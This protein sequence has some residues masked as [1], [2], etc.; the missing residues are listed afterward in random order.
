MRLGWY[1]GVS[2]A[3]AGA[4]VISAFQQ[5]ANFYSAMV[6]LAQSNFC[7]LALVNFSLL[8]YSSFI[9]G[10][11]K[12]CFGTLRAVEVEQLTERAWFAIT[13]TCLAM[14][15]FREEIGAWFLV[16]FT[17]LVTGKVWGWIGDGRVEFLEQQPPANPRLFHVRL[18]VSL[19]ISFIYDIWILKYTVDT[20]I[21]QARPNM[22]VMF[23]FEFAV[24]ATC[25][26]RTAVR[27]I[28]SIA[29][30]NIVK[31]Q[32]KK[33]L[34][35]RR[36]EIRR[37][38]EALIR[39]REQAAATGQEPPQDQEP[40]PREED[41]DE[42]DIEVP[43]WTSKGEW[44]LWLD[45]VTDMIK[46]GIYIAFFFMLLRFYGLPI[47]IM[48][49]LFITSR[50][51]I[52]RLNALL[53]YR[54][55]IQEMNRYPDATL[56]ELSQENTCII[57]REE[58]RPWDPVNHPGAIDRVRPKKL[59]CGH[60]LHLGC[61]KSWL[62]R[63]Q[64]CPTCRSPVT[65]DRVR[66]GHN[67]AAGLQIQIGG[68][69]QVLAG[70]PPP[71]DGG[72]NAPAGQ[73]GHNGDQAPPGRDGGPR[74][75]NLGPFR[76]GFGANDQQARELA[77]QFGIPQAQGNRADHGLPT[78][79]PTQTQQQ[80]GDSMQ[81]IG[82]LLGQTEQIVQRELQN[83]QAAQQE[84][85][86]AHLLMAELQRLRQRRQQQPQDQPLRGRG[87]PSVTIPMA[88]SQN[89]HGAAQGNHAQVPLGNAVPTIPPRIGS[90]FMARHVVPANGVTIPAGSPDLPEGITLPPGWSLI[91]LQ[92]L[93]GTQPTH[94]QSQTTATS[95]NAETPNPSQ[96]T[97]RPAAT[98]STAEAAGDENSSS[99]DPNM[100]SSRL[101]TS[102][103][104]VRD[105]TS[106]GSQTVRP[107]PVVS[108][109]PLIPNWGGP[110]QL[111][112]N[113]S[114]SDVVDNAVRT[115]SPPVDAEPPR[116]QGRD[117]PPK[118][119]AQRD[120]ASDELHHHGAVGSSTEAVVDP[121]E[122][123][124]GKAKAAT[125]EEAEEGEED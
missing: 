119:L 21:Q 2:T 76:L 106:A 99:M 68:G 80:S 26:W 96:S 42:M 61:L 34:I 17:S 57:C 112:N 30:Q 59:P 69:P 53:R 110:A 121:V 73:Q 22:M 11:T 36:Q 77:Q 83:L 107:T 85:Q 3:L 71:A 123:D 74:V 51:F 14:T 1:A 66:G 124:K 67:R 41:I 25:S 118:H 95:L 20:V 82:N 48:R 6:Y 88:Q 7:L 31:A 10:L 29:E 37:Q 70:Q 54:R 33:R 45:L 38:R 90:P 50:D 81:Q 27:Y 91:P 116:D 47:H 8:L 65:M 19:A 56:E 98:S 122:V 46:L 32:T 87:N 117:E 24:L 86:V 92:R 12:L 64:V 40:L 94:H 93:D 15:I 52:K 63:Q 58:M 28:L 113:R 114:R 103:D 78:P 23:L 109:S 60:V 111:F 72:N 62:E 115:A 89:F 35:E 100:A 4:V 104:S 43:G 125:V 39:E 108:P 49:D 5:R 18:S 79:T 101:T 16:M 105:G 9:Y 55:A 120:L 97:S 44:V 102:G 84:L 75:F 13:E